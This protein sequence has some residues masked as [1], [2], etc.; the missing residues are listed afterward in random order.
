MLETKQKPQLF[1]WNIKGIINILFFQATLLYFCIGTSV[2]EQRAEHWG[3]VLLSA[4]LGAVME[5]YEASHIG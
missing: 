4:V 2:R 5:K 1:L 3:C